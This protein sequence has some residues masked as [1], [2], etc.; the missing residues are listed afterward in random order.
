MIGAVRAPPPNANS[1]IPYEELLP[2]IQG[3]EF[4]A[5]SQAAYP[6]LNGVP[7]GLGPNRLSEHA[8][9]RPTLPPLRTVFEGCARA[10]GGTNQRGRRRGG[11]AFRAGA[12]DRNTR[13]GPP[14]AQPG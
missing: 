1:V 2:I 3:T 10:G 9:R 8:N 13:V 14:S 4:G 12:G 11:D 5:D 7:S 6:R